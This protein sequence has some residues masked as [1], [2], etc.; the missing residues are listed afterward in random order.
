MVVGLG[1]HKVEQH[2]TSQGRSGGQKRQ[3]SAPADGQS[4]KLEYGRNL[5]QATMSP[6]Q[7]ELFL[8]PQPLQGSHQEFAVVH[9]LDVRILHRCAAPPLL[10]PGRPRD[11]LPHAL[12]Q[13]KVEPA[14]LAPDHHAHGLAGPHGHAKV[15]G[16]HGLAPVVRGLGGRG[17][18]VSGCVLWRRLGA[19]PGLGGVS[20]LGAAC[21]TSIIPL[22]CC[23]N[24]IPLA[25][26]A[27]SHFGSAID[28][29][30]ATSLEGR[31]RLKVR[32]RLVLS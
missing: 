4:G 32:R 19:G 17:L 25:I 18:R 9:T 3:P 2:H 12:P 22:L 29:A 21:C 5:C 13:R 10:L 26:V 16:L 24:R 11:L 20:S 7:S 23:G 1:N 15:Q 28:P 8:H 30:W 31:R 6:P 27:R 14:G